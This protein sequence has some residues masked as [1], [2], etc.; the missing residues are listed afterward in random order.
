MQCVPNVP[1]QSNYGTS[2]TY[3]KCFEYNNKGKCSLPHCRY[4]HRCLKCNNPHPAINCRVYNPTQNMS[5]DTY[6]TQAQGQGSNR[7]VRLFEGSSFK[8]YNR[9]RRTANRQLSYRGSNEPWKT[10][11]TIDV[12][13]SMLQNYPTKIDKQILAEGFLVGFNVGY[14]GPRIP[15]NCRNLAST[16][17]HENPLEQKLIKKT[18]AGQNCWSI[19]LPIPGKFENFPNWPCSKKIGGLASY[20]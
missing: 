17:I 7:N 9:R 4:L 19:F 11:I 15:T 13:A 12:L 20:A 10:P 3:R 14:E 5:Q 18:K 2:T 8:N 16:Y 6:T 1:F